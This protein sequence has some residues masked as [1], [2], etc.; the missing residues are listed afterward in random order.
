MDEALKTRL[1]QEIAISFPYSY[2]EVKY[3]F[4]SVGSIDATIRACEVAVKGGFA[5]PITI[6]NLLEKDDRLGSIS[7]GVDLLNVWPMKPGP[8]ET[9]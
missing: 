9:K 6:V 2:D 3:V 4:D 5:S 7:H 1:L 8:S